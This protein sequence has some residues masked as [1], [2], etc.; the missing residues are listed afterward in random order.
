MEFK[1]PQVELIAIDKAPVV[2]AS[3]TDSTG[4]V[5]TC[6]GTWM[7]YDCTDG[8]VV[9]ECGDEAAAELGYT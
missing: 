4:G 9:T 1:E 7:P 8:M 2:F 6:V 3:C 5:L